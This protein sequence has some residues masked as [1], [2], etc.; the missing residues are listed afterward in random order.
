M[1]IVN[2]FKLFYERIGG[3]QPDEFHTFTVTPQ[4]PSDP[5]DPH[6]LQL[7]YPTHQFA[8]VISR[9]WR[10]QNERPRRPREVLLAT[11]HWDKEDYKYRRQ[12][13]RCIKEDVLSWLNNAQGFEQ[14]ARGVPPSNELNAPAS[15]KYTHLDLT[16]RTR[17]ACP[18]DDMVSFLQRDK[19]RGNPSPPLEGWEETG[20]RMT[21]R[22]TKDYRLG[23]E[24]VVTFTP[25]PD[26]Q[27]TR[28]A[29]YH[30]AGKTQSV[31]EDLLKQ[32]GEW[33]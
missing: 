21:E 11:H 15:H 23:I 32:V 10:T 8:C 5:N 25:K 1:A 13:Q 27:R 2:I 7:E 18:T 24:W 29:W 3:H 14:W 12:G 9:T 22:S 4:P 26:A 28:L 6:F 30:A 33:I 20:P 31:P 17:V 19:R 16:I